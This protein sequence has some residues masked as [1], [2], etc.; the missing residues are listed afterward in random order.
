MNLLE[1]LSKESPSQLKRRSKE[2]LTWFRDRVRNL[3][4]G[5]RDLYTYSNMTKTSASSIGVGEMFT[6]F[7]N[8]KFAQTLPYYDTF[9][10]TIIIEMN[11]SG[12]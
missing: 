5:S 10:C 8:P 7:Y 3:K 4:T 6:Y 9:P 2:S 11:R 12:F 1:T